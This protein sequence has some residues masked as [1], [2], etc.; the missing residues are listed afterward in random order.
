MTNMVL[1]GDAR[2]V[3]IG[4]H[5]TVGDGRTLWRAFDKTVRKPLAGTADAAYGFSMDFGLK[6]IG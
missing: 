1:P 4:A 3:F 5:L 6:V 2:S